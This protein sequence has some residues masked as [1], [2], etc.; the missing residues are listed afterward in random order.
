M[1]AVIKLKRGTSTPDT[2]DIASGEVAVDTSAKKL[3][4]NDA[5]TVKEIGGGGVSSDS[6][7]NTLGGT[8]AGDSITTG[9][10]NTI[11]GY[12]AGTDLEGTNDCTLLGVEAGKAIN[13]YSPRKNVAVG[14]HALM[15]CANQG[16]TAVGFYAGQSVVNGTQNTLIGGYAGDSLTTAEQNIFIGYKSGNSTT[17][18]STNIVIGH[19]ATASSATVDAQCTIGGPQGAAQSAINN[20]RVPGCNFDLKNTT[21]TEDYVLTVDAN[22]QCGWE[23]AAG[24]G[25]SNIV[26]DT[27]PQLGGA[28]DGQNN[29]MS[30]IGTIDGTNLQL[31]FGSVA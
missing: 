4:I 11:F 25:L 13:G 1:A 6:N 20:F 21:A 9:A 5:G 15:N 10:R 18:G 27:S 16:N 19:W 14:G 2:N 28:L 30:N 26:E 8:N 12:N 17:T 29:N 7:L 24:G 3:Y 22:G 23:A 31:D